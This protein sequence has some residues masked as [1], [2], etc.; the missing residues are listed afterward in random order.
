LATSRRSWNISSDGCLNAGC[1]SL[2]HY[3]SSHLDLYCDEDHSSAT[4]CYCSKLTAAVVLIYRLLCWL[5][6]AALVVAPVS[7]NPSGDVSAHER[8]THPIAHGLTLD[9]F[10]SFPAA[11]TDDPDIQ[12][13][14]EDWP[15]LLIPR[16]LSV[17]LSR[18][19]ALSH[20]GKHLW[21]I[22]RHPPCAAPPTGPPGFHATA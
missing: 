14:D 11:A 22:V 10:A 15:D 2:R 12:G 7:E 9:E 4:G 20:G 21:S 13:G 16:S 5:F 19:E 17:P 18:R 6:V 3:P 1:F 8:S